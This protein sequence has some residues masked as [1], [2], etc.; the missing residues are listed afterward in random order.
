MNKNKSILNR[1]KPILSKN[2]ILN[3]KIKKKMIL[4]TVIGVQVRVTKIIKENLE[5]IN[6]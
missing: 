2:K 5:M 6:L 3:K 1:N 4:K